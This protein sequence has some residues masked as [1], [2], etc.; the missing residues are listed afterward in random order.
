LSLP[1]QAIFPGLLETAYRR[2]LQNLSTS[3]ALARLWAKDA[4]LWPAE[5]FQAESLKSNLRWLDLPGQLAP[6]LARVAARAAM[7]EPAGFEDVVFVAMGESNLAARSILRLPAAK[8]AKKTFLLDNIDP[9]SIRALDENLRLDKTLFIF[10]SKSGKHIEAHS[11]LL[12][13]L[14]RLRMA[15]VPSPERHFVILAEENSYLG[16]LAGEYEFLDS[17]FDPPGIHGRFSSLIHFNFF[18]AALCRLDPAE[19][20]AR[21][22]AMREACRPST[23][24]DANPALSLGA[25]LAAAEMEG[26]DRLC[27]FSPDTLHPVARRIGSLVGASTGKEGQGIIPVFGRPSYELAML[28]KGCVVAILKM[29]ADENPELRKRSDELL[30]AGVPTITIELNGPEELA[31]EMFKWEI[32]TA[33]T[34][35][36]L[37]V[38]PF[39]DPDIRES[40]A[41]TVEI[42][43]QIATKRQSPAL[44]VRVREGEV[45]LYA[46]GETRQQMSTLNMAEALRTFFGLRHL[47]GYI[48]LLPFLN[49]GETQKTIFRRICERLEST[50]G[51][52]VLLTPGPRYLHSIG[53]LYLGGPARGLFLLLTAAPAK[54]LPIPGAHY[55][56]GQLQLALALG[57][58]ESLGRRRRPVIRLHLTG[59]A[60]SGLLQLET[61]FKS[62]LGK[63]RVPAP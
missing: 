63:S 45:E 16:E 10:A 17:F 23:L 36:L 24:Q 13:F 56:F 46:E 42:L 47:Q 51:L 3:N 38:H 39:H 55:S 19:L 54:D 26:L 21:T 57:D 5:Q 43:E 9:D 44:T 61:I 6:L 35:S 49:Y 50:L 58:F 52:P 32:A 25:F 18:L 37:E 7:I 14:E 40:R 29:A 8:L 53:Q 12:Y 27:F 33:L 4:S 20:L 34:C 62:A 59:G 22:Q 1:K 31:A 30:A 28:R 15:A 41:R 48:A 60:E 2:E 11:L